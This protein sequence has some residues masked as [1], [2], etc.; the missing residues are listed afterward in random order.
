M[1][2]ISIVLFTILAIVRCGE[3]GKSGSQN[4]HEPQNKL[5]SNV[6]DSSS[7]PS[8]RPS[9]KHF[10]V[11][12]EFAGNDTA[13]L[14]GILPDQGTLKITSVKGPGF[15]GGYRVGELTQEAMDR[16]FLKSSVPMPKPEKDR[17]VSQYD[18]AEVI[19]FEKYHGKLCAGPDNDIQITVS[20]IIENLNISMTFELAA[21][22]QPDADC[23][24]RKLIFITQ[25]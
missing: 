19:Y 11:I 5:P 14:F 1:R 22:P 13:A 15:L 12:R 9:F 21:V 20:G 8:D 24:F 25:N 18:G 16:L 10:A 3:V 4:N 7:T 6:T 2:T 17:L 23:K